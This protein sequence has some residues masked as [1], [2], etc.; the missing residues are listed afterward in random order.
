MKV[1]ESNYEL[2]RII[3]TYFIVIYQVMLHGQIFE[4]SSG[5][6][7][8]VCWFIETIILVHVNSFILLT[9][10][11][12]SKSKRKFSK[13]LSINNQVWFYRIFI[14]LLLV[15]IGW[16]S[17]PHGSDLLNTISPI[18]YNYW[19]I[20]CYLILYLI[21]PILNKVIDNCSEKELRNI[22]ILLF[23]IFSVLST[24]TVDKFPNAN[25][26]RSLSTFILLYFIGGYLNHYPIGDSYI[27]KKM[28]NSAK[29]VLY[30]FLFLICAT[31]S[32]LSMV[33][34][35]DFISFGTLG[36]K[37]GGILGF[38]HISYASPIVILQS[39]FYLL[40]FGTFKFKS[41]IVNII[42]G[43]SLGIYI[44]SENPYLRSVFYDKIK[45]TSINLV[46]YKS[47]LYVFLLSI[48]IFIFCTIIELIRKFLFKIVYNSKIAKINRKF[49]QGYIKKMG[50]DI[51][52]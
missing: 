4:H 40:F 31:I 14:M 43:T 51:N 45:I 35:N 15:A 37:I 36:K 25:T 33:S 46:T 41:K 49:Y 32:L 42:S 26:G 19:Y 11:F 8:I 29:R 16:I 50:I 1:R 20:C 18:D 34:Y 21:S 3:S 13:I 44:I 24:F 47:I 27:L 38:I 17:L 30:L 39:V 48:G 23:I 7:E 9:G 12:Q 10:Y 2:M 28:S 5:F 52:W 6:I 22:I